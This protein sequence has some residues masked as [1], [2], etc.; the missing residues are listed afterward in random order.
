[1]NIN[2]REELE[3]I[4]NSPHPRYTKEFLNREL[5]LYGA[6]NL[7]E[8]AV[9]LMTKRGCSPKSIIDK[10]KKGNINN[11]NIISP[12]DID[13]NDKENV[14]FL[15]CVS[16]LPYTEIEE[17]LK[18]LQCKKIMHFYTW[19]YLIIPELLGNGWFKTDLL[20]ED[21]K[22]IETVCEVL[23]H[24]EISLS[25]YLQ[26]LWWKLCY[27]EVLYSPVLSGK[28]YFKSPCFPV[29]TG[30]EVLL[31]AGAHF[32][33]TIEDF[34]AITNNKFNKIYSFE[35]DTD[36]FLMAKDRFRDNRIIFSS[37]ALSDKTGTI[38]FTNNL[39]FASKIDT[40]GITKIEAS[41]IDDLNI[42]PSIIKLHVEG[43]E[44]K[45]LTGAQK[46]IEKYNPILMVL[47]DHNEDG[48]YKIPLF[49][50]NL[51][52]YRLYFNLHDYCGNTAV[53][54]AIPLIKEAA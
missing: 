20:V 31:D 15:I 33:Q 5:I 42:A 53:F 37:K 49:I 50:H 40:A 27:K 35:P 25:H 26:F 17:Y 13:S 48:L 47:A 51:D 19:A 3:K 18:S 2:Y 54:Y 36:N 8:M 38:G 10:S 24:D 32:G 16:T 21:K 12:E 46:T 41:K 30:N 23:S 14:L 11:I 45:A 4:Y 52:G 6:G 29:L 39:G 43:C 1:M 34:V 28:K 7:G 9:G 22:N 44:L